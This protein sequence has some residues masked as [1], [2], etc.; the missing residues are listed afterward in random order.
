MRF[1]LLY[2]CAVSL[3]IA[4]CGPV[5]QS[6]NPPTIYAFS[7]SWCSNCQKDKT[8]LQEFEADGHQ[9]VRFDIDKRPDLV[10]KYQITAV[11][12]YLVVVNGKILLKTHNIEEVIRECSP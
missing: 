11:P 10:Q 5:P 8:R 1:F 6:P 9:V 3:F 4:G 2:I 12:Y 7:A